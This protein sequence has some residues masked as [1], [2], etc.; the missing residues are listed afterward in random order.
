MNVNTREGSSPEA[1]AALRIPAKDLAAT[2]DDLRTLGRVE[3]ETQSGDEITQQYDDLVQRLK[4]A[5][6]AEDRLRGILQQRTGSL[7][8][9]LQVEHSITDVRGEIE[10][11]EAEQAG[12]EHR[13]LFASVELELTQQYKAQLGDRGTSI[14]ARLHNAAVAGLEHAEGIVSSMLLFFVEFGPAIVIWATL[15]GLPAFLVWRR[16]RRLSR[17]L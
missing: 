17:Q 15:L 5:H 12:L 3:T 13:I 11:M 10:G 1:S 9:V 4:T 16:Y 6:E 7:G 8:D 14:S 2:L